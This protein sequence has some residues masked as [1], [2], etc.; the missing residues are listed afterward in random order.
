M[1]R[2]L[3]LALTIITGCSDSPP[4]TAPDVNASLD[5]VGATASLEGEL[6]PA[7]GDRVLNDARTKLQLATSLS[8]GLAAIGDA[9][10][11]EGWRL[12]FVTNA[13]GLGTNAFRIDWPYPE[14]TCAYFA[15]GLEVA[16]AAPHPKRLFIQWK[17]HFGRTASGSGPGTVG[18]F[19]FANHGCPVGRTA[20]ALLRSG[21]TT[22]ANAVLYAW[23]AASP[24]TPIATRN[25]ATFLVAAL[26]DDAA[27][28][29]QYAGRAVVHTFYAQA[30]SAP[31]ASD[32]VV[33]LWLDGT[34]VLERAQLALDTAAFRGFLLPGQTPRSRVRQTEYLWDF[35][36]WEPNE[37]P[38]PP[39]PPADVTAPT[40]PQSVT[41]TAT[42]ATLVT[43]TWSASTD[44]FGVTSYRVLR[45]G[46][47]VGAPAS[48]PFAD[49]TVAEATAYAYTVVALDAAGN[50]SA[51]SAPA[52]VT[53]PD[54]TAPSAP[55][56]LSA[57]VESAT[58]V[59]LAWG[60]A[61]D[62]VAVTGYR[63]Y[64]DAVLIGTSTSLSFVDAGAREATTYAYTVAA[65]DAA[66]HVSA[67]SAAVGA[68]TPDVSPPSAPTGVSATAESA[69]LVRI[70]WAPATDNVAVT[71][72]RVL[73]GGVL[74]GATS[75]TMFEDAT[76]VSATSY[77]YTVQALDA[78]GNAGAPGVAATVTTPDVVPPTPP[79]NLSAT[80]EG[81]TRVGLAW[82]AASDNVAVTSY[83]V[84][85]DG[86]P[87]GATPALAFTDPGVAAATSYTY[88]VAALD[89]AG[90]TSI[91][92]VPVL[93]STP[94]ATAPT[95]PQN[96]AASAV[97]H[98]LVRLAWDAASD[99][100]GVAGY[101]V[102]RDGEPL[103]TP[104]TS[105][106]ED[107]TVL[108]STTYEYTVIALDAA[109]NASAGGAAT[110]TT[111]AAPDVTAPAAPAG[112][113]AVALGETLV[114]LSWTAPADEEGVTGYSVRR[115]AVEIATP[116]APPFDDAAVAAGT[117]YAYTVIALDAAG[118]ASPPSEAAS[119][120]TPTAADVTPPSTPTGVAAELLG[121]THVRVTWS[122]SA[123]DVG[124]VN[125]RVMR[126]S[127]F[128]ALTSAPWIEDTSVGEGPTYRYAVIALD[129]AGNASLQSLSASITTPDPY[130]PE[131]PTNLQAVVQGSLVKL[132][133]TAAVDNNTIGNYVVFRDDLLVGQPGTPAYNDAT[134][135]AQTTYTYRVMAVDPAGNESGLSAPLS[136]TTGS[137]TPGSAL[138]ARMPAST[139]TV[140]YV[141]LT[142]SDAN[143]GTLAAPWRTIQKALNVLLPGQTALVR[144]GTYREALTWRRAG[145]AAAPV[146]LAAYPGERPVIDGELVR[147]PL[148]ITYAGKYLRVRGLTLV[149]DCCTSGGQ[150]D[151]Y[152]QFIEL[153]D[154]EIRDGLGKGM[155]FS[156]QSRNVHVIGN[157][158][159]H[160]GTP[161]DQQ[162]HGLYVQGQDHLLANNLIHDHFDGFGIQIYPG[163]SR[164]FVVNNTITHNAQS[165]IVAGG[166]AIAH[167]ITIRNNIIAFNRFYGVANRGC[168]DDLDNVQVQNN[169]IHGNPS[170][171]VQ[172][173]GCAATSIIVGDNSAEDPLFVNAGDD[174]SRDLRVL[175]GS[176]AIDAARPDCAMSIAFGGA[177]R[178]ALSDIGAHEHGATP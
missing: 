15:T 27:L 123:D 177:L 61:T 63:V 90:N 100:V 116:T 106:F 24:V 161:G 89:A 36:V 72:Y 112:L 169:V 5:A 13:D 88:T 45:D 122:E 174:T 23:S 151:I 16:L 93:V 166:S 137:A 21:S 172:T 97:D 101:A 119:V 113:T 110:V 171:Q 162:D 25:G 99:N 33:R 133:W 84:L 104:A 42:S 94:D 114:R 14:S 107:A 54:A 102:L 11:K 146:T 124:V 6:A 71:S 173:L 125:Y 10:A 109:G 66:G 138:P 48:P 17:Q 58:R 117:T 170:G 68:T 153:A 168:P 103:A 64:R 87:I 67:P 51:S 108:P 158:V 143:P 96:V 105:P 111:P 76:A 136:V 120:T 78:A 152:G 37:A 57:L 1:R 115:D 154:N 30:E 38:P 55:Q 92:S 91:E 80:A 178:D 75:D 130:P 145:T 98:A 159:H 74:I 62:N 79:L 46:T 121:P 134:A 3:P 163:A 164:V 131:P 41:A 126:N 32:G 28:L 40:V 49:G 135:V 73:R 29:E 128:F 31:G 129:A 150:I 65:E 69:T 81:E 7:A 118:N 95:A 148:T 50:A 82:S 86:T 2:V 12:V 155:Y 160:N 35:L 70:S 144:E 43:V 53:T 139:G 141:A 8:S 77:S 167:D 85:R 18:S 52:A 147:R 20:L 157:H 22:D 149:R 9:T 44:D 156:S 175:A 59:R 4:P 26:D 34:L 19:A 132:A 165:G 83:R 176:P 56:D 140:F 39:P 60:A 142:G 127:Q 47:E